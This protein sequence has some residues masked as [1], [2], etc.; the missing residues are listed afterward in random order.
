MLM[1]LC[2]GGLLKILLTRSPR[3]YGSVHTSCSFVPFFAQTM[4]FIGSPS[5]TRNS[6]HVGSSAADAINQ[7]PV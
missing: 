5:T 4:W 7:M 6:E 2:E 1:V 3:L